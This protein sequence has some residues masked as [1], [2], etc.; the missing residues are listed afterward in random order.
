MF[1]PWFPFDA[2]VKAAYTTESNVS[3]GREAVPMVRKRELM[4]PLLS[5]HRWYRRFNVGTCE[6]RRV[7]LSEH[8]PLRCC[9]DGYRGRRAVGWPG[10]DGRRE[11]RALAALSV[12]AGVSRT[13]VRFSVL[14]V[15]PQPARRWYGL[16]PQSPA[17]SYARADDR[18]MTTS[19]KKRVKD[20]HPRSRRAVPLKKNCTDAVFLLVGAP[21]IP[22]SHLTH[23]V[24]S[25][26]VSK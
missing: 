13:C 12:A 24:C 19:V 18:A 25:P 23:G 1:S 11:Q 22:V 4:Q 8:L 17:F 5:E 20:I 21:R 9:N 16:S 3:S 14:Q 26:T 10:D 6:L 15:M 7:P 2:V